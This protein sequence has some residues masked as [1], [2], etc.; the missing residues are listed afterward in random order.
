MYPAAIRD[1]AMTPALVEDA[2]GTAEAVRWTWPATPDVQERA[3]ACVADTYEAWGVIPHL[4]DML[5]ELAAD[6]VEGVLKLS[7]APYVAL[8]AMIEARRATVSAIPAQ[9]P[10]PVRSAQLPIRAGAFSETSWGR[11]TLAAGPCLYAGVN[12]INIREGRG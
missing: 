3:Y 2:P 9:A 11:T 5:G 6:Y 12:L 1:P 10:E 4:A 7:P 8:T